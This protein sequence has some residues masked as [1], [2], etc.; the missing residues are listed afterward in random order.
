MVE[1]C[2]PFREPAPID[3]HFSLVTGERSP[4]ETVRRG[5][6]TKAGNGR[7]QQMLVESAWTC[8]YPPKVG[9]RKLYRLEKRRRTAIVPRGGTVRAGEK[10]PLSLL[11]VP[12]ENIAHLRILGLQTIG[13]LAKKVWSEVLID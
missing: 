5:S 4:G 11:R 9:A 8:R 3:G 6:I 7:V 13:E 2:Q 1:T 10:L 12:E